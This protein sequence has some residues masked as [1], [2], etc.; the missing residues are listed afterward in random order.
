M[1]G[2]GPKQDVPKLESLTITNKSELNAIWCVGDDD[3]AITVASSP[4]LEY[5]KEFKPAGHLRFEVENST[6]IE[7]AGVGNMI[8][9]KAAGKTKVWATYYGVRYDSIEIEVSSNRPEPQAKNASLNEIYSEATSKSSGLDNP[10]QKYGATLVIDEIS[11]DA[12][13]FMKVHDSTRTT[14]VQLYESSKNM[15]F[16]WVT[17]GKYSYTNPK[18]FQQTPELMNLEPG[19]SITG[20]F[21]AFCY[22]GQV[23]GFEL[24]GKIT[25]VQKATRPAATSITIKNKSEIEVFENESAQ[26]EAEVGPE[27]SSILVDWSVTNG[28]GKA[29]INHLGLLV[30][31][32]AGTITVTAKPRGVTDVS[33]SVEITI[34][35]NRDKGYVSEPVAGQAYKM[36]FIKNGVHYFY[37]GEIQS[38]Y[39]GKSDTDYSKAT[40]V[41]FEDAGSGKF[42]IS[43]TFDGAKK[44]L[45]VYEGGGHVNFK[46]DLNADGTF[47]DGSKTK[48]AGNVWSWNAEYH[49]LIV[50]HTPDSTGATPKD[51]FFCTDTDNSSNSFR[52]IE[53]EGNLGGTKYVAVHFHS[54][55]PEKPAAEEITVAKALEIIAALADGATSTKQYAV[56]G[57]VTKKYEW[58]STYN[59]ADFK[60][61]DSKTESDVTKTLTVL[62]VTGKDLFDSL[63]EGTTKVKV[64]C[65]LV[66]FKN[67]SGTIV[68][69]TNAN[70]DYVIVNA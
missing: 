6:I 19:D 12:K 52:A 22:G 51:Y 45:G 35:A 11:Y 39:Y 32:K 30:A 53:V 15:T 59:N 48:T 21:I 67:N 63:T 4:V 66:K 33:D 56:V 37:T 34:G 57:Y 8:K 55:E 47:V 5:E 25:S 16:T 29:S 38:N 40:D 50:T 10:T 9:A 23:S 3:R 17:P 1:V 62:R 70:P 26:L 31:N 44:Y 41:T 13:G 14:P 65:N 18:D 20:E 49:T 36:S 54:E 2:C 43:H 68:P 46:W 28:T 42:K 60:I 64:T 69:E 58:N 61:A 7:Y 27:G 24:I